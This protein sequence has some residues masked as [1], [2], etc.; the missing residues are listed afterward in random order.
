ML[1]V[2][3]AAFALALVLAQAPAAIVPSPDPASSVFPSTAG[4]MLVTIKPAAA[5]DY[6]LAV[7]TLQEAMARTADPQRQ[8]VAKGW[9][10]FKA[11]ESDAKGNIVY[12]HV[13]VPAEPGFDY[14][15]SLL[16]DEMVPGLP[17]DL[18]SKYRD[19]FAAPPTKLSLTEFA[20]MAVTPVV[21]PPDPAAAPAAKKPGG[22]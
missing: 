11:A 15:L 3:T 21:A 12:V 13:L 9:T 10:V 2:V 17:P 5:A 1:S 22:R 4:I 20:N 19:A 18:L 8:R 7:R 14:R 6:E 16:V